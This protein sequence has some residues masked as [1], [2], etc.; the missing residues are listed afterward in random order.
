MNHKWKIAILALIGLIAILAAMSLLAR[1]HVQEG[2][3][4]LTGW[5]ALLGTRGYHFSME[6]TVGYDMTVEDVFEILGP[7]AVPA[8][9]MNSGNFSATYYPGGR[10]AQSNGFVI[11]FENGRVSKYGHLTHRPNKG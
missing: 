11:Y 1:K 2:L 9:P 10:V 6:T 3:N 8:S 7:S 4:L 5:A